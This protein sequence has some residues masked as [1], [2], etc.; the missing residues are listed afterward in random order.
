MDTSK[1]AIERATT[2]RHGGPEPEI[3]HARG[4]KKPETGVASGK[5]MAGDVK[6]YVI[7]KGAKTVRRATSAD[8]AQGKRRAAFK[9]IQDQESV[10]H[11]SHVL[12]GPL[13]KTLRKEIHFAQLCD[14]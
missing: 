6:K 4:S 5:T 14:S 7:G 9:T 1:G 13:E 2:S 10:P 8:A 12:H 11:P 3:G